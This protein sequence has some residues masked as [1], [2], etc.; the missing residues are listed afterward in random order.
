MAMNYEQYQN[1]RSWLIDTAET[2]ADKKK[3]AS[4]LAKLDAQWQAIKKAKGTQ[5]GHAVTN[6]NNHTKPIPS[7]TPLPP[8]GSNRPAVGNDKAVAKKV[9]GPSWNNGYTN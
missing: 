9:N 2:P 3:L 6:N 8:E 7:A 5:S 1:K 4:D